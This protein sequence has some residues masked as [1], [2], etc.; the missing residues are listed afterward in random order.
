V[1]F[2]KGVSDELTPI[3]SGDPLLDAP[4]PEEAPTLQQ[5]VRD[6]RA[7]VREQQALLAVLPQLQATVT[8][9]QQQVQEV[10]EQQNRHSGN[11]SRPPSSD[12]PWKKRPQKPPTGKKRGGQRSPDEMVVAPPRQV[13]NRLLANGAVAAL[14]S[15][16]EVERSLPPQVLRYLHAG[17]L[18]EVEFPGGTVGA[19]CTLEL[20]MSPDRRLA[21]SRQMDDASLPTEPTASP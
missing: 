16:D 8:Q 2:H 11:S 13:G 7:D 4:L 20:H 15:P 5:M 17:A 19:R 10:T 18:L 12:P 1:G 21:S 6:L 3:P 9:L 14:L